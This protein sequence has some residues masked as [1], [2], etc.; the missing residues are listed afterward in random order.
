VA[1]VHAKPRNFA[2]GDSEPVQ[3]AAESGGRKGLY[4]VNATGADLFVL[5]CDDPEADPVSTSFYSFALGDKQ[6]F[7]ML[8]DSLYTGP[9]QAIAATG[10]LSS[11]VV[12][13]IYG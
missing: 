5:F 4:L 11:V 8:G 13:E 6:T 12:T 9:I 3:V 10:G 1:S 2:V 7:E